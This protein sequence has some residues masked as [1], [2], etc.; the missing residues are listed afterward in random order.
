MH[1]CL[2]VLT[3]IHTDVLAEE[4]ADRGRNRDVCEDV[5][6]PSDPSPPFHFTVMGFGF[7]VLGLGFRVRA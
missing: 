1:G 4:A 2:H 7:W 3:S 6:V 5:R